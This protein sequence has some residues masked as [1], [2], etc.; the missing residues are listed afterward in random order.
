L[1]GS[2]TVGNHCQVTQVSP[3]TE[4]GLKPAVDSITSD[5]KV[6]PPKD[7]AT[8]AATEFANLPNNAF[9]TGFPIFFSYFDVLNQVVE[10]EPIEAIGPEMRGNLAAAHTGQKLVYAPTHVRPAGALDQ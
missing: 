2:L 8:T 3:E 6:Y 10:D 9:S 1:R 5:L 7:A 4:D